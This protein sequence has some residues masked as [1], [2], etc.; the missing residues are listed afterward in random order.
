MGSPWGL[1]VH[2]KYFMHREL[3]VPCVS[4][5]ETL[6]ECKDPGDEKFLLV[7]RGSEVKFSFSISNSLSLHVVW[8]VSVRLQMTQ[9]KSAGIKLQ[10]MHKVLK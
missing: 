8:S 10:Q 7:I 5:M 2:V 6:R 3:N 4:P 1:K 9:S